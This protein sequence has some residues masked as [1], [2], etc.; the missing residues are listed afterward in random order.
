MGKKGKQGERRRFE[1]P[2]CYSLLVC[3]GYSALNGCGI[4]TAAMRLALW[5]HRNVT[6]CQRWL[7]GNIEPGPVSEHA[8]DFDLLHLMCA[9]D[10]AGDGYQ[11][12]P[13]VLMAAMLLLDYPYLPTKAGFFA[14]CT[15]QSVR[16]IARRQVNGGE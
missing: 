10:A 9:S 14:G 2:Y 7:L 12:T 8:I 3:V 1:I 5:D 6:Y 11:V 13:G 15:R 16:D 4:D